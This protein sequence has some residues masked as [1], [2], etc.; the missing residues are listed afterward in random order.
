VEQVAWRDLTAAGGAIE[1]LNEALRRLGLSYQ[2]DLPGEIEWEYACRAGTDTAL[3]DGSNLSNERDDPAL[4]ALAVYMRGGRTVDAPLPVAKRKANA[5]GLFD[6]HGNVAEWT[7]G[8]R[9]R[10]EP[11]LRGGSWKVGAVHCRAASR[12]EVTTDTRPTDAMGYRLLL[13]SLED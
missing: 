4:N 2:A 3:S 7:Y 5:W 13:R 10:R 1:K 6:M 12:V 8:I 9:G 11:V